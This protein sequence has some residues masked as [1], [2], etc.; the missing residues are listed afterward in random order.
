[1]SEPTYQ[2]GY[3]MGVADAARV[4]QPYIDSYIGMRYAQVKAT[5][6]AIDLSRNILPAIIAL[7]SPPSVTEEWVEKVAT[8]VPMH[9]TQERIEFATVRATLAALGIEVTK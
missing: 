1:M 2:Q 7:S 5:D 9:R 8:S 6:V 4:L 3:A